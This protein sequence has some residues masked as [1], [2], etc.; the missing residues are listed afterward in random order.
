ML[1][2]KE[3]I[4]RAVQA[5]AEFYP[6]QR[7]YLR[8]EEVERLSPDE[9]RITVSVPKPTFGPALSVIALRDREYKSIHIDAETGD[10]KK[11]EIRQIAT[12]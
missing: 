1:D 11:M 8:L 3:A 12:A 5:V 10:F 2:V 6:D 7:G 4:Q 9:W